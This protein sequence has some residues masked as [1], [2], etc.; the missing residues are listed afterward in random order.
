MRAC[1]NLE[2]SCEHDQQ[3]REN[4]AVSYTITI[5]G[6][7][8]SSL[9][10]VLRMSHHEK[11]REREMWEN[12]IFVV[13]GRERA[14]NLRFNAAAGLRMRVKITIHNSRQYDDDNMHGACKILFDAIRLLELIHDD[15]QEY[16]EQVVAQEKCPRKLKHTVIEIG[17][18]GSGCLLSAEG[19]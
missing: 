7:V 8:P 18:A 2:L 6:N 19:Q 12:A 9:N 1:K 3:I 4:S 11:K 13:L 5:P 16:L 14:K 17:P 15:R 10:E